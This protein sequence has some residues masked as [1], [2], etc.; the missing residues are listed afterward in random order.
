MKYGGRG[1]TD[2]GLRAVCLDELRVHQFRTAAHGR[3]G[4]PLAQHCL[5]VLRQ[6]RQVV[7][8]IEAGIPG[9]QHVHLGEAPHLVAVAARTGDR[10][11]PTVAVRQPVAAGGEH[12]GGDEPLDIPLP[13]RGQCFVEIIDVKNSRRSGVAKPPKFI[14]WASPHAWTW[15]SVV[16]MPARSAAMTPA[17]PR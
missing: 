3:L 16:G 10:G 17:D 1:I 12:E 4:D 2:A 9:F 13:W 14:R 7:G 8:L 5:L 15:I 6:H 11:I